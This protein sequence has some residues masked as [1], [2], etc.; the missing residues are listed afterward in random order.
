MMDACHIFA[1]GPES[2]HRLTE[3]AYN[4]RQELLA[5]QR[6]RFTP[7]AWARRIFRAFS[8]IGSDVPPARSKGIALLLAK[9]DRRVILRGPIDPRSG[10]QLVRGDRPAAFATLRPGGSRL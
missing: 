2:V 1:R 3:E 9:I 6:R 10:E 7:S 8:V 4:R 5:L